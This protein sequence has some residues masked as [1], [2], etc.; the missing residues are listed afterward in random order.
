MKGIYVLRL[1]GDNYYVG[2]SADI[3]RRISSHMAGRGSVWTQLHPPAE[4]VETME[5][6]APETR[7]KFE[8]YKTLH[9]MKEKGWEKV[10]GAGWTRR[11]LR[12]PRLFAFN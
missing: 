9:L 6:N 10:R 2:S 11:D 5:V 8:R 1:E 3:D 4:I 12:P 7:K